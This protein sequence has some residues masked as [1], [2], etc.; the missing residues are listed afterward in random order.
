MLGLGHLRDV[1]YISKLIDIIWTQHQVSSLVEEIDQVFDKTHQI[2]KS[3]GLY[4]YILVT[5]YYLLD[6]FRCILPISFRRATSVLHQ[7]ALAIFA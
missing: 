6:K 1:G 5:S 4:R 7:Q 2:R 3:S